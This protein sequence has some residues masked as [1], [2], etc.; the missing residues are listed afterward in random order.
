MLVAPSTEGAKRAEV[1]N[2][3]FGKLVFLMSTSLTVA[4]MLGEK[5]EE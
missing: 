1:A 2:D 3:F 5:V 4:T